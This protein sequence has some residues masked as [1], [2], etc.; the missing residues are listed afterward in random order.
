MKFQSLNHDSFANICVSKL[1]FRQ[2]NS[3]RASIL[4][5]AALPPTENR[6]NI[7][8]FLVILVST[9]WISITSS[10]KPE[11]Q[12]FEIQDS[13]KISKIHIRSSKIHIRFVRK[14]T[15]QWKYEYRATKCSKNHQN[16]CREPGEPSIWTLKWFRWFWDGPTLVS[17]RNPENR[18]SRNTWISAD[19]TPYFTLL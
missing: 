16:P 11:K 12:S 4:V 17:L 5:H 15:K 7:S 19:I 6:Q 13:Q 18:C 14:K 8:T 3:S 1:W 9:T 10:G 2:D